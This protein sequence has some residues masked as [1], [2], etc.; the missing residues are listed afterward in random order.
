MAPCASCALARRA[1]GHPSW[2][3]TSCN[4][5]QVRSVPAHLCLRTP[6]P[7]LG[8]AYIPRSFQCWRVNPLPSRSPTAGGFTQPVAKAWSALEH[9]PDDGVLLAQAGSNRILFAQL[10]LAEGDAGPVFLFGAHEGEP[11]MPQ[12]TDPNGT[13]QPP[14]T[15]V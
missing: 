1:P 9:Q 15:G 7:R 3:R 11:Q 12:A 10:P 5:L 6:P 2:P 13:Q 4:C 8:R 14:A